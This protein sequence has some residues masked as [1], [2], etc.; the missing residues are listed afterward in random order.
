MS[1]IA[2]F[3]VFAITGQI[4]NFWIAVVVERFSSTSTALGVFFVMLAL[5]FVVAWKLAVMVIDRGLL[6]HRV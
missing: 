4:A 5:I 3:L 6:G 2:V 1:L